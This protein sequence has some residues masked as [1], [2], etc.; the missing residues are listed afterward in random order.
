MTSPF[1]KFICT[2]CHTTNASIPTQPS[3]IHSQPNNSP[4]ITLP[5]SNSSARIHPP[6]NTVTNP[7]PQQTPMITLNSIDRKLDTFKQTL[8]T[9]RLKLDQYHSIRHQSNFTVSIRLPTN[10]SLRYNKPPVHNKDQISPIPK[11]HLLTEMHALPTNHYAIDEI[12]LI[13]QIT[14]INILIIFTLIHDSKTN[15]LHLNL[16]ISTIEY[17]ITR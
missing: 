13:S 10:S 4:I 1:F 15:I 14:Y 3:P 11:Y 17:Y 9:I 8:G 7:L 6:T 5:S 2:S 16:I 12:Y